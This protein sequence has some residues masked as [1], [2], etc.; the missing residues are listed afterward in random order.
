MT[1]R[2]L[3]M[4]VLCVATAAHAA[5]SIAPQYAPMFKKGQKWTYAV[6]TT[7]FDRV[8]PKHESVLL[9]EK[10][11]PHSSVTC[12]V[13]DVIVFKTATVSVIRCDKEIDDDSNVLVD[14]EWVATKDGI[15]RG[16]DVE[17]PQSEGDISIGVNVIAMNPKVERTKTK[18]FYGPVVTAVTNPANGTWCKTNDTRGLADGG[19]ETLCFAAGIGITRGKLDYYGGTPRT[20]EYQLASP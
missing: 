20:V 12:R 15:S 2:S 8:D 13:T 11:P 1:M 3:T 14:G 17:L 6:T 5:P 19:V 10:N 16:V 7:A 18:T 4:L 9:P